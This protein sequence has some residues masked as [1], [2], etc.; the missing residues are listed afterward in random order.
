MRKPSSTT[1]QF[2][3]ALQRGLAKDRRQAREEEH[4]GIENPSLLVLSCPS[5]YDNW[6]VGTVIQACPTTSEFHQT[7]SLLSF[8]EVCDAIKAGHMS[9]EYCLVA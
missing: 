2:Q 7:L 6:S 5:F 3:G 8:S 9:L 4:M 1:Q